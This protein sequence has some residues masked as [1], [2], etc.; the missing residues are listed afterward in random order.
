MPIRY[1]TEDTRS[2]EQVRADDRIRD[3][4]ES[5]GGVWA[6]MTAEQRMKILARLRDK[7]QRAQAARARKQ[8]EEASL[9]ERVARL[10]ARI[11]RLE[12]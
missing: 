2:V 1:A 5:T 6:Q 7:K 11:A 9:E 3:Q 8:A 12:G 4:V 10:E